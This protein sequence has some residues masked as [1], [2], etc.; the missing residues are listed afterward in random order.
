MKRNLKNR[1]WIFMLA[2]AICITTVLGT[3]SVSVFAGS[4]SWNFKNTNFKNLKSFSSTVNVDGLTL[5]ATSQKPMSV[6]EN[7]VKVNGTAYTHCLSTGGSGNTSYRNIK[8]PVSGASTIKVVLKSS[9]NATRSLVVTDSKGKQLSSMSAGTTAEIKTYS[10]TGKSGYI[11]LYSSNSSINIYKIQVALDQTKA[12][13]QIIGVANNDGS[14]P[15]L[16]F[17]S[18]RKSYIG[19]ASNDAAVGIR[20]TGSNYTI[21]NLIIQKAPDNGIQIKGN[22]AG[23][24]VV[25]DCIVRYN[26]DAGVQIT[27]GA[28]NNAIR[29]V[30][31]YRNCDVYTIGGNADG[32]AP[33]LRAGSGNTFYGCYAWENSDDGWDSYDKPGQLTPNLSYEE[34]AT[35]N[36]GDP[37]IFTGEYDLKKGNPL[38]KDLF[39]VE[40]LMAKDSAFASNYARGYYSATSAKFIATE[41]GTLNLDGW[42]GS[43]YQGNPNGFKFGSVNTTSAAV[44]TVKNCLS[45]G[46]AKKGFDNNNSKC[47]GLFT[48][49]VAFDNGYNYYIQP[50]TLK[51]FAN[52]KTFSVKSSDKLP[53]GFKVTTPNTAEQ[54]SIRKTVNST[55][56]TITKNCKSNKIV[57]VKFPIY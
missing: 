8:V 57:E 32:F 22:S 24:N 2:A 43:Y 53:N 48:N 1:V 10:Y 27:D 16:D 17:S 18:F 14:Y 47:T 5:T 51:T 34:C 41:S 40:L 44:R 23:N 39:L 49:C 3:S 54:S 20:I 45:F 33:K 12:N 55:V 7:A 31:S 36:N 11:C 42:K 6:V 38:D 26:N 52:I 46:H 15:V 35:W 13:V 28:Y 56:S 50:F 30:Y 21:T 19:K 9:G 4:I 25:K 29:F 37:T